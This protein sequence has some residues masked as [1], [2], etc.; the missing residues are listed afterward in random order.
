MNLTKPAWGIN[1][2]SSTYQ[3]YDIFPS[4]ARPFL[5]VISDVKVNYDSD[6]LPGSSFATFTGDLPNLNVT[7]LANT[8]GTEEAVAGYKFIGQNGTTYD[9]T[10]TAKEHCQSR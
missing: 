4:C 9:F 8:I 1:K 7:T 10:C 5:L 2:G 6:Q 3:P